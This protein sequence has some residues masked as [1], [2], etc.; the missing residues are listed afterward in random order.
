MARDVKIM[1]ILLISLSIFNTACKESQYQIE[2]L[3]GNW[4]V[5][6]WEI[7]TTGKT[8]GNTMDMTFKND[9]TY[10]V[11]YGSELESGKY[12]IANDYL[13]TVETNESEKKVKILKLTAD[14]LHIQMNRAGELENVL[15]I[16]K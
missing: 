16:R 10:Q 5:S 9:K 7:L 12:W 4:K 6:K 1:M 8:R 15:L 13:H 14:T 11:N 2:N 3:W